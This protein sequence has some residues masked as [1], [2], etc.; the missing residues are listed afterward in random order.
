MRILTAESIVLEPLVAAH[1]EAMYPLLADPALYTFLDHGPPTSAA[2]LE[3]GWRKLES[4][5]SP[6]GSEQWL[7]WVLRTP[8]G[9]LAGFVQATVLASNTAWVAYVVGRAFQRRG[10]AGCATRAMLRCLA[11]DYGIARFLASVEQDNAASRALLAR[12]AFRPASADEAAPHALSPTTLLFVRD[13][14]AGA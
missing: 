14:P 5:R 11:G 4:R 12:L 10:Y 7:N 2:D 9:A 1:A 3:R 13:E 8:D 6:D